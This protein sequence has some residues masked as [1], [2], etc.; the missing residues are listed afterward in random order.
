MD[1][2]ATGKIDAGRRRSLARVGGGTRSSKER[3]VAGR[4]RLVRELGRG[5]MGVVWLAYD[6]DLDREVALKELRPLPGLPEA[7]RE[8]FRAGSPVAW[9]G[10]GTS[11]YFVESNGG[12]ATDYLSGSRWEGARLTGGTAARNSALT[13]APG[14]GSATSRPDVIFVARNGKLAYDW[15]VKGWHGPDPLPGAPQ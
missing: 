7:D 11:A 13:Y 5:G 4:Y 14:N 2:N 3:L 8:V 10:N 9:S 6:T 15:Y 1:H 12:V